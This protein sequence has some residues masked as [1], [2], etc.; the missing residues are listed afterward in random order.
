MKQIKVWIPIPALS[1]AVWQSEEK[2][3]LETGGMLLGYQAGPCEFVVQE[4]TCAGDAAEHSQN[5]FFPDYENDVKIISECYRRSKG[6][7]TYLGDWHS[8]PHQRFG[9]LSRKDIGVLRTISSFKPARNRRPFSMLIYGEATFSFSSIWIFE[10]GLFSGGK[11][12]KCEVEH[13]FP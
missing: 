9:A 3:P 1:L 8:H 4:M 6:I 5:S 10:P 2:C 12:R 11:V 7:T 13:Y